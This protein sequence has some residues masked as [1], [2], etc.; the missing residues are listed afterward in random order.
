MADNISVEA[1]GYG[2]QLYSYSCILQQFRLQ[3]KTFLSAQLFE[4][5]KIFPTNILK[6]QQWSLG[7]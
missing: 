2:F 3:T 1:V 5:G 7:N 6:V 4:T